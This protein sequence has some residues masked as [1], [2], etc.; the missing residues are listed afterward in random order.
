MGGDSASPPPQPLN[1][2]QA[3]MTA[4]ENWTGFEGWLIA[5]LSG[6]V[7]VGIEDV[8]ETVGAAVVDRRMAGQALQGRSPTRPR[9]L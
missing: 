5:D 6:R 8:A 3:A 7:R 2:K 4:E 9:Q 1:N